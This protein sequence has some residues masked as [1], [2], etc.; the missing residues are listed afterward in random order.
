MDVNL[1]SLNLDEAV[2]IPV[3][4]AGRT[5]K[6]TQQR[7]SVLLEIA[8]FVNTNGQSEEDQPK[9]GTSEEEVMIANFDRSI[10]FVALMF[11]HEK[12]S[13]ETK[14]VI[15]FLREN[16]N[17]VQVLKVFKRWW[18]LNE[19]DDFFIRRGNMLMDPDIAEWMKVQRRATVREPV[20]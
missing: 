13:A 11:G 16:I 20:V 6:L 8:R 3:V 7:R 18:E 9:E 1:E 15:A 10:P 5:F 14:E 2:E 12:K 4:L 17:H 19:M